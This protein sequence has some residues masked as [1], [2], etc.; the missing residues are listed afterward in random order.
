MSQ[1]PYPQTRSLNDGWLFCYGD[2]SE[3]YYMGYD[4]GA[5]RGVTLPH[6]WAVEHPFDRR[7]ASGTGYLPGGTGWYRKHFLLSDRDTAQRVV[8][9][10]DGVYKHAQVWINSNY[11]GPHAYGYTPFSFDVSA[12]V[13]PGENVVAVRVE[14]NDVADSRWYTGSGIYRNVSLVL[15]DPAGFRE[16]GVFAATLDVDD[17][18]TAVLRVQYETNGADGVRLQLLDGAAE[19]AA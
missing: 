9:R 17:G 16:H 7:H 5:W 8:L 3:A 4:D 2:D 15:R 14:H 1:T 18:E 6:D 10:F 19:S 13:R 12:F 11:L